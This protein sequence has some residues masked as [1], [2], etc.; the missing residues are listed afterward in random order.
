MRRIVVWLWPAGGWP[1]GGWRRGA[2]RAGP[3]RREGA[4]GVV[5]KRP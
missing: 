4:A 2:P 5:P 1:A 3:C